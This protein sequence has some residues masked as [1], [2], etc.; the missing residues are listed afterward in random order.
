MYGLADNDAIRVLPPEK[1]LLSIND[2]DA[3]S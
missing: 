3:L 2:G 1:L